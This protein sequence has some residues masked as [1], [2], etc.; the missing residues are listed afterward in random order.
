MDPQNSSEPQRAQTKILCA[1]TMKNPKKISARKQQEPSPESTPEKQSGTTKWGGSWLGAP[2]LKRNLKKTLTLLNPF[3]DKLA[4]DPKASGALSK[5][6]KTFASTKPVTHIFKEFPPS[7]FSGNMLRLINRFLDLHTA[8]ML[9]W[10]CRIFLAGIRHIRPIDSVTNACACR[11]RLADNGRIF[12]PR[13][14]AKSTAFK[15]GDL[16]YHE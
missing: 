7:I 11:L 8:T 9:R 14:S 3:K 15:K 10:A 1:L 16:P 5:Q 12:F 4:V 6:M 2:S 13:K